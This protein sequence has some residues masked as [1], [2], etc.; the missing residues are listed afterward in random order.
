MPDFALPHAVT[1]EG[2][3]EQMR[4][5]QRAKD[6]RIRAIVREEIAKAVPSIGNAVAKALAAQMGSIRR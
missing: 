2:L 4:N 6:E 5:V 1:K 3:D